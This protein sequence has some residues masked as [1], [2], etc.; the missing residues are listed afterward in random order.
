MKKWIIVIVLFFVAVLIAFSESRR[1][2]YSDVSCQ[3][4]TGPFSDVSQPNISKPDLARKVQDF[5][6]ACL[7]NQYSPGYVTT[8]NNGNSESQ[9]YA[10]LQSYLSGDKATFNDVLNWTNQ[11]IKRGSDN[12]LAWKFNVGSDHHAQILDA[13]SATDADTDAAYALLKAGQDWNRQDY[14]AEGKLIANDIWNIETVDING[15]RYLIA[16]PWANQSDSVVVNPSY[17]SPQAYRVFANFD[18]NHDWN[19][20]ASDSYDLLTRVSDQNG[21]VAPPNW[22]V[23]SKKDGSLTNYAGKPDSRDFGYDAFR[24]F[25]RIGLDQLKTPSSQSWNYVSSATEFDKDW[26]ANQQVC[27]LYLFQNGNYVCDHSTTSTLAAPIGVFSVTNGFL[28]AQVIQ[29][30][31]IRNGKLQF[32]DKDYYAQSWHWFAA[33]LWAHS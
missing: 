9:A 31:Y 21:I 20:L 30:Y 15:K 18:I 11:N 4:N 12:L 17:I 8:P 26:K 10:L 32:P 25:W 22:I 33:W 28:A 16:G 1:H 29:K 24:T 23:V 7:K 2:K 14:I 13:N 19:K 27:A 6:A 3:Q 5:Y